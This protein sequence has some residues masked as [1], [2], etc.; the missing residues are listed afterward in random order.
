MVE[1]ICGKGEIKTLRN[2]AQT[3]ERESADQGIEILDENVSVC[4]QFVL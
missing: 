2:R 4:W 1:K 3:L